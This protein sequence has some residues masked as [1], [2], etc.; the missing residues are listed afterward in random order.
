M[1][2]ATIQWPVIFS[3]HRAAAFPSGF[4]P[5]HCTLQDEVSVCH[6]SPPCHL[7]APSSTSA[8]QK[9]CRAAEGSDCLFKAVGR[10][11]PGLDVVSSSTWLLPAWRIL[12]CHLCAGASPAPSCSTRCQ[13]GLQGKGTAKRR[14]EDRDEAL[15]ETHLLSLSPCPS[16]KGSCETKQERE[17][18]DGG[19]HAEG[20]R[21][22]PRAC[23]FRVT[24]GEK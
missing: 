10:Q 13:R 8:G 22:L 16:Y 24:D 1:R 19:A 6:V 12:F 20:K 23:G 4:L 18:K 9:G 21:V 7:L 15:R 3:K 5:L 2:D 14:R 17:Y 11:H